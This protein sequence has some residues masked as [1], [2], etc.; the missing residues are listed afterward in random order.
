M[1]INLPLLA[2][3]VLVCS[4]YCFGQRR[5]ASANALPVI[6]AW[7]VTFTFTGSTTS[8]KLTFI[9]NNDG[10]GT[11][12]IAGP[13]ASSTVPAVFPSVW[14]RPIQGLMSFSSEVRIQTSNCCTETGTL[15][16]KGMQTSNGSMGGRVMF[17]SD[18]NVVAS[19]SAFQTRTGTFTAAPLPVIAA[20][21]SKYR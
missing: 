13:R 21:S 16:F 14:A 9:A 6:G 15:L 10:T 17:V 11:F 1:K 18:I 7:E 19:P 2:I 12:R 4:V 8:Q 5:N 20:R 3:V